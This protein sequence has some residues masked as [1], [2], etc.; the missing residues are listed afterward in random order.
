MDRSYYV[1]WWNVENL[2]DEEFAPDRSEKL[3]R[4]LGR[5]LEGWTPELRDAKI[6][7]LAA[8]IARMN[9][10]EGPDLLGV[11]E[12]ENERVLTL[13]RD[14]IV[15]LLPG[16]HYGFAHAD[17]S[18]QRGID[19]AFLFD[20]DLFSAGEKF[21]H[22]VMRRTAT[23]EILQVTFRTAAG[24]PWVLFANHWPSRSGGRFESDGYR[25]I[26][27]E[28]LAYFHQRVREIHGEDVPVLVMGDFN[29]EPFDESLVRHALRERQPARVRSGR[30]PYLLNLTLDLLGEREGTF[31]FANEPNVLDQVLVNA[32]MLRAGAPLA[33]RPETL[34][35]IR[36]PGMVKKGNYPAPVPFGGMG[37]PVNRQGYSDHSPIA[38][39]VVERV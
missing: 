19:V 2:F 29:D 35:L 5:D 18:D 32:S 14:A 10:G 15:A 33:A 23:R 21:Q 25:A 9:D 11:C 7:Q 16:R 12:I 34:E 28:T 31:Y 20:S 24:R 6:A 13:L 38:T 30:N 3:K 39:T 4:A 8:V 36:F 1:A 17:T 27:G 37:K 26:A 22:V